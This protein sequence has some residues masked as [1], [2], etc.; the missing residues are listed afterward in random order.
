MAAHPLSNDEVL[1]TIAAV[2]RHGTQAEAAHALGITREKI[3][4]R[5]RLAIQRGL[6]TREG[7]RPER[8]TPA[9][10]QNLP[11]TADECWQALDAAIGRTRPQPK[12]PAAKRSKFSDKRIAVISDLHA[13]FHHAEAIAQMLEVTQGY[14]LLCI[15]GDL[16]DSY[17]V[18]RFTKH[19]VVPWEREL[20][21]VDALLGTFAARYPD[22]LVVEGNHDRPRFEK[23]LRAMLP[24]EMVHVIEYLTQGE[25]S[26]IRALAKRRG[27]QSIRFGPVKVGRHNVAWCAQEG[28]LLL[29]HAEAYSKVPGAAMRRVEEWMSNLEDILGLDPWRVVVQAHT[30]C[31]GW[32]P[33][34]SSK[35]LVEQGCLCYVHP[36]QLDSKIYGTGQR[37]GFVTLTQRDGVTDLASVRAHWLDPVLRAA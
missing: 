22:V 33:W 4:H 8:R 17:S 35:L 6:V 11:Q 2:Q 9:I 36:Y 18:S 23:A 32:F 21:A 19:E 12:P 30:H 7:L 20:A 37:L 15:N 24:L 31:L 25:F 14:D 27:Y 28:D 16:Q 29:S 1:A 10:Y 5:L 34:K 3:Q 13:P 26:S